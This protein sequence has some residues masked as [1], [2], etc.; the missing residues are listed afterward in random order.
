M[1][2][3]CHINVAADTSSSHLQCWQ[4]Q[5]QHNT[6]IR[7]RKNT[8]DWHHSFIHSLVYLAFW[9]LLFL[10]F[11]YLRNSMCVCVVFFIF[12]WYIFTWIKCISH[13]YGFGLTLIC[14]LLHMEHYFFYRFFKQSKC[15]LQ[16]PLES[17]CM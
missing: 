14:F 13:V 15:V 9:L 10:Y 5:A 4:T 16:S 17:L 12:I 8:T 2:A 7:Y 1:T 6:S 11:H 3:D